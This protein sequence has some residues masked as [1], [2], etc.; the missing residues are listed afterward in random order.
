MI[1]FE[2]DAEA[3]VHCSRNNIGTETI[4]GKIFTSKVPGKRGALN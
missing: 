1:Q 4:P 2:E 3:A